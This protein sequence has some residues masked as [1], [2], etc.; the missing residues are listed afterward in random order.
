VRRSGKHKEKEIKFNDTCTTLEPNI[1][2]ADKT[3]ETF[4]FPRRKVE[5]GGI[6]CA[7]SISQA[8]VELN[9]KNHDPW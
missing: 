4:T 8:D 6:F 1:R 2:S 5:D 9:T 7:T 3:A